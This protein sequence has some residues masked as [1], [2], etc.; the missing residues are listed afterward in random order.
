MSTETS[1]N[2]P[3]RTE[4]SPTES[5]PIES[6][7]PAPVGTRRRPRPWV[8]ALIGVIALPLAIAGGLTAAGSSLPDPSSARV[9]SAR[10]LEADYG[11]RFDLVAVTASGGL[12]DLR[13]T[14]VDEA[15]A[16]A[17]FHDSASSPAL[18]VDGSG[19]VLR[20]KKGMS[21]HLSL[22]TGGRYFVLF[23]NKG[24]AVQA[25]THVSVVLEDV[26]LEPMAAQS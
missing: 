1:P 5:S 8:V 16:K 4:A 9:V 20:T 25:G 19:T 7:E 11:I 17:L 2:Q 26:R 24:G 3:S 14:V 22:L 12:V 15:K 23:S 18:L 6:R 10:T 21:H 13:F